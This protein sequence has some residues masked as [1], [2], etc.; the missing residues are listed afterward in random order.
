MDV[1]FFSQGMDPI[2]ERAVFDLVVRTA[3]TGTTS[4]YFLFTPKVRIVNIILLSC[5]GLQNMAVT[6]GEFPFLLKTTSVLMDI[7]L[8]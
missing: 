5:D 3:C 4:Q 2:N 8:I 6:D 7:E 1:F